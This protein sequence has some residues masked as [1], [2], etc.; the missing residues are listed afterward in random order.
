MCNETAYP[1]RPGN[2]GTIVMNR[3]LLAGLF[4]AFVSTSAFAQS[5][6][7]DQTPSPTVVYCDL[8]TVG[9]APMGDS[10]NQRGQFETGSRG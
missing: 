7:F 9:S 1:D 6:L 2:L 10:P 5:S 4:A 3:L 8:V